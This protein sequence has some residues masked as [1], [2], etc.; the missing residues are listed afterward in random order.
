[1]KII[2]AGC[3]NYN[4]Y[5]EAKKFID[6]CIDDMVDK[7]EIVI[8]SGGAKGA[9][10]LGERYAKEKNYKLECYPAEWS[11]YGKCAG[12]KRNQDMAK[13][14]DVAICFWDNKSRGT[15]SLIHYVKKYEKMV[16][17]KIIE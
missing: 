2:V 17:L 14:C 6:G 5:D 15:K 9:D 4:N 10:A 11:I 12:P 1:M 16:F 8:L 3:R 7:K 13:A